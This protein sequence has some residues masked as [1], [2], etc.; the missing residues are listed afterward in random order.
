MG[1]QMQGDEL[2]KHRGVYSQVGFPFTILLQAKVPQVL[3]SK[4]RIPFLSFQC[5]VSLLQ[6][7]ALLLFKQFVY[8]LSQPF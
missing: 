4:D 3:C 6:L 8:D 2:L 5:Q 1:F 7:S